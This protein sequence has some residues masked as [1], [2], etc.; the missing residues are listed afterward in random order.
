M[1]TLRSMITFLDARCD[2]LV[3]PV[4]G[5][6]FERRTVAAYRRIAG[7]K[8]EYVGR[9]KPAADLW[10]VYTDGYWIDPA[11][12]GLSRRL[13]F[14]YAQVDLHQESVKSGRVGR[15]VNTPAA[16]LKTLK[17][18]FARL[19]CRSLSI[20][21]TFLVSSAKGAHKLLAQHRTLVAKPIWGGAGNGVQRLRG[22]EDLD[23]LLEGTSSDEDK[24]SGTDRL[25]DYAFQLYA[26][27]VEKRLWFTG[28]VC[29]GGRIV[30]DRATPWN[31]L[32]E[33]MRG[34]AYNSG[35]DFERDVSVATKVWKLSGLDIGSVDFLGDQINEINGCGTVFT[36]CN[37]HWDKVVDFR[38]ELTDYLAS[39]LS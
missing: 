34:R 16:E 24:W 8:F 38:S 13:D 33:K 22:S 1:Q 12:F 5:Y 28:S 21:P 27:G 29:V 14:L 32:S 30:T 37:K 18:W 39:L 11:E 7:G 15:M 19:D 17:N 10:I 6:D 31:K 2:L 20:I 3:L 23:E 36:Y 9:I 25:T 35:R 26:P 4:D